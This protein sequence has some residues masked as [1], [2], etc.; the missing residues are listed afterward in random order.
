M[1]NFALPSGTIP[2]RNVTG[3]I[4]AGRKFSPS[5]N[6]AVS[7]TVEICKVPEGAYILHIAVGHDVATTM[8][9]DVGDG[10]DASRFASGLVIA[11]D[12]LGIIDEGATGLAFQTTADT[13]IV[14]T[15]TAITGPNTSGT[16]NMIVLST[17]DLL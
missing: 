5:A 12:G 6:L 11:S 3:V 15:V 17:M 8:T 14:L 13:T 7:D 16:L 4:A 1:A 2:R 10:T 9:V